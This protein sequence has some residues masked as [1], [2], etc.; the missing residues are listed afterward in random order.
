MVISD[1]LIRN[2]LVIDTGLSVE[3]ALR[4]KNDGYNVKYC[5]IWQ[6]EGFP[7]FKSYAPGLGLLE[8][9]EL[10]ESIGWA[11]V[12]VFPDAGFGYLIDYLRK[13]GYVVWGAGGAEV[14]ELQR[15]KAIKIQDKYKIPYPESYSLEGIDALENFLREKK[16]LFVK[17]NIFRGDCETFYHEEYDN[18]TELKLAELRTK[19]GPFAD[20]IKFICQ[21]KEEGI[22]GGYDFIFNGHDYLRPYL[23]GYELKGTGTYVGKFSDEIPE[24]YKEV[25]EK[26]KP[27][28]KETNYRGAISTEGII[29]KERKLKMID[30]TC[31]FPL[32]LS[33]FYTLAF[34]NFGEV[35]VK[36]ALGEDVRI[37]NV[38]PYVASLAL[39]SS[40]AETD[41]LALNI[42][43]ELRPFVKTRIGA[44]KDGYWAV[45][46]FPSVL[47]VVN[48]GD[49]PE[50]ALNNVYQISEK[51]SYV[52]DLDLSNFVGLNK[53]KEVIEEGKK[54]GI[55]F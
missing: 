35:I 1:K 34:E 37:K 3:H 23:Y 14:L 4:L 24:P 22:E 43:E 31:R 49:T 32:P 6:S 45:P 20:D 53:A 21:E 55:D 28:L 29:G 50:E 36:T 44:Y 33:A 7:H 39:C 42:P 47:V 9:D 54:Y 16:D 27:Y 13:N 25:A 15:D 12:L 40:K 41:W 8:K 2:I 30:W 51:L 38:K 5:T 48:Y 17:M 46:G 26:I 18:E 10:F 52:E 11:D 19:F